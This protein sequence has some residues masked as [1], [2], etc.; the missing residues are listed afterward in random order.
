MA[1]RNGV[2]EVSEK[3]FESFIK[4]KIAVVDFWASWCM[5]CLMM[6]PVIEEMAEKF[7]KIEFAKVN[8]DDNSKISEKFKVLSI[9]TLIIFKDGKE[10]ERIVGN[11]SPE[12]IE[13]K[14][15]KLTE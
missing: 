9:P 6:S 1:V 4:Q 5:P 7:P 10:V 11:A 2:E 14:L 8:V 13:E 15:K 12:K 3:K